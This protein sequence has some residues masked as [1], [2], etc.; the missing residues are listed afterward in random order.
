MEVFFLFFIIFLQ[1]YNIYA[2]IFLVCFSTLILLWNFQPTDPQNKQKK[3]TQTGKKKKKHKK[4]KTYNLLKIKKVVTREMTGKT[5]GIWT[6]YFT[7][8]ISP[9]TLQAFTHHDWRNYDSQGNICEMRDW[10]N[11]CKTRTMLKHRLSGK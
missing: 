11:A 7:E 6:L 4:P 10:L 8:N 3:Q 2:N 9:R 1:T 5:P